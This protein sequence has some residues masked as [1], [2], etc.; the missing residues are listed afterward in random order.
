MRSVDKQQV[1]RWVEELKENQ[2]KTAHE[3]LVRKRY[4]RC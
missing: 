4:S 1:L 3:E 2:T